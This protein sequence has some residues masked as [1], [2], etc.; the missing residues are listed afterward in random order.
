[1]AILLP[2]PCT[3]NELMEEDSNVDAS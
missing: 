3:P 2:P 1:M